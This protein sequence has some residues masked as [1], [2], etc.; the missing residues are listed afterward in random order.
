MLFI[1]VYGVEP[2]SRKN[3]IFI[4]FKKK[5]GP[6][7]QSFNLYGI[8]VD[9]LRRFISLVTP[10]KFLSCHETLCIVCSFKQSIESNQIMQAKQQ[11]LTISSIKIS[12]SVFCFHLAASKT[13]ALHGVDNPVALRSSSNYCNDTPIMSV[14]TKNIYSLQVVQQIV[15][16]FKNVSSRIYVCYVHEFLED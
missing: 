11:F 10:S 12:R 5:I 9:S 4:Y 7:T 3:L 15:V 13:L 16:Y 8:F 2:G 1:G 6:T 14:K